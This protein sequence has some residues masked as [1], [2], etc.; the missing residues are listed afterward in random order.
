MDLIG[1]R[2]NSLQNKYEESCEEILK[3]ADFIFK[4]QV[5]SQN[6]TFI[7]KKIDAQ[8]TFFHFYICS[9]HLDTQFENEILKIEM[10]YLNESDL[11]LSY[12]IEQSA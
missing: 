7:E 12:D 5:N 2:V 11:H 1:V 3:Q 10:N 6:Q 9:Y 4:F 8:E